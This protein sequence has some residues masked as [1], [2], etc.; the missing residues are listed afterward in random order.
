EGGQ[1][2]YAFEPEHGVDN[3]H[4]GTITA[5]HFTPQC[6][7]VSA[8]RDNT[9]RIW[10]LREKGAHLVGEPITGRGGS[11][12][13]LGVSSDGHWGLLDKGK[14]LQVVSLADR[15][16]MSVVQ[17]PSGTTPFETL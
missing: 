12:G 7:L 6:R 1:L 14:I 3:P 16:T 13:N 10:E 4:Q 15:R 8:S 17:N 11:V 9:M 5:L 2:L